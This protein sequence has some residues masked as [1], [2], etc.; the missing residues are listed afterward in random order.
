MEMGVVWNWRTQQGK[1]ALGKFSNGEFT[2]FPTSQLA[3]TGDWVHFMAAKAI[4]QIF[5]LHYD[6]PPSRITSEH[7]R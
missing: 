4:P 1:R 6:D 3:I 7:H 2:D 5:K